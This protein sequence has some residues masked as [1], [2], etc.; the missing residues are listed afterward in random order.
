MKALSATLQ[1]EAVDHERNFH[2]NMVLYM[3]AL[4]SECLDEILKWG[5][6]ICHVY[7]IFVNIEICP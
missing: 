7:F 1:M 6:L 4:T 3:K 5:Y 2:I